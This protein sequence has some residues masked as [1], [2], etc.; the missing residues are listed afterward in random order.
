MT[1][2]AS[3]GFYAELLDEEVAVYSASRGHKHAACGSAPCYLTTDLNV[4]CKNLTLD[5]PTEPNEES[6]AAH[7]AQYPS[8]YVDLGSG[9]HVADH[10]K[11]GTDS[12]QT[13]FR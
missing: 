10:Y 9:T 2:K 11:A 4:L 1:I 3:S 12:R 13:R 6:G 8:L 7:I 5:E